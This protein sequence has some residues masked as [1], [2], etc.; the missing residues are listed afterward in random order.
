[1]MKRWS[2]CNILIFFALHIIEKRDYQRNGPCVYRSLVYVFV[3][4]IDNVNSFDRTD[5]VGTKT[6]L[7]KEIIFASHC[8]YKKNKNINLVLKAAKIYCHVVLETRSLQ[9]VLWC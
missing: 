4:G 2:Q 9:W 3:L 1:M 5:T 7:M 6:F 8:C